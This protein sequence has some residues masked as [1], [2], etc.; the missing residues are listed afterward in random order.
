MSKKKYSHI[1]SQ[2]KIGKIT[3]PNRMVMAPMGMG[4]QNAA[5][6]IEERMV[7]FYGE[8]AQGGMGLILVEDCYVSSKEE[9]P[10]PLYFSAPRIDSQAKVSAFQAVA[11]RI[12]MYGC[13]PG[14]QLGAGEGRNA[15]QVLPGRLPKTSCK[16]PTV[17]SKDIICEE[18]T[19]QEITDL[20]NRFARAAKLALMA[21]FEVIEVHAHSGYLLEQF[22]SEAI[23]KRTDE[24]GGSHENRFRICTE[25]RAAIKEAVGDNLG[26][27]IRLS[28]DHRVPDG[29]TTEEGLEYAKL[30]E[31]AGYDAIHVD[32]GSAKA[33]DWTVPSP[34][35]GRTPL[36]QY[37]KLV[38]EVV[39]IPVITVGS[40]LMPEDAEEALAAGDA[41]FV[42][43]GRPILADPNWVNKALRGQEDQ[44]RACIQC[45]ERCSE[46]AF[47][48]KR[49]TCSV[50]PMCGFESTMHI[51]P[52]DKPR[53]ITIVGGGPAGMVA[54]LV[55]SRRGHKVTLMEQ[56][57]VLGGWMNLIC[58]EKGK[59]GIKN[60]RK[61]IIKQVEDSDIDVRLGCEATLENIKATNPDA[62]IAATG[63]YLFVPGFLNADSDNIV[64][65]EQLYDRELKG[66]ENIVVLGGGV[67]GSEVAMYLAQDGHKVTVVEM[68]SEFSANLGLM[69]RFSIISELNKNENITL[70]PNTKSKCVEGNVLVCE[71][72][73]GEEIRLPF[74]LLISAIGMGSNKELAGQL[75]EEF[76]E[77]YTIGDA[78]LHLK[79][80]DAVHRGFFTALKL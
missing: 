60:Y 55:A 74:D 80:G 51:A 38:K 18:M 44:I 77:V 65:I 54:G 13:V 64:T 47:T 11:N 78:E 58:K 79:I 33:L 50:N 24:Y 23:N 1:F 52:A 26:V 14:L 25:I 76:N 20:V 57:D 12:K 7:E 69:N 61:Y 56:K 53:N 9:D 75:E 3:I 63:S 5:A 39:N 62:V 15:R 68:T 67:N 10:Y 21:G 22:L 35:I 49:P 16:M 27:S 43:L 73:A 34:Y 70:M 59:L 71:N 41:D 30:A 19:K 36:R 72:T 66:D 45:N 46:W 17:Y 6:E 32:A 29:I 37:A 4:I 28:T 42:C 48:S 40:Y 2:G 31:K 8:R